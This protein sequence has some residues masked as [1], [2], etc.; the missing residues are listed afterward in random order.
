MS[1]RFDF[2]VAAK[3]ADEQSAELEQAL[4]TV[5][6]DLKYQAEIEDYLARGW[7][8]FPLHNISAGKCSCGTD[9]A[10]PGKHPRTPNGVKDASSDPMEVAAWWTQWPEANIGLATGNGLVVLDVDPDHGGDDSIKE[11]LGDNPAW[12][13]PTVR[14]GSGGY[15][16]YFKTTQSV[17]NTTTFRSLKGIDVRGDGGYVVAPPSNHLK[18]SYVWLDTRG[19]D[20]EMLAWPF[21]EEEKP[22]APPVDDAIPNGERNSTLA[23]LAGS[24]RRRGM[25][26]E[27]ILAALLVVNERRCN[28]P[29]SDNEVNAIAKSVSRYNP[30]FLTGDFNNNSPGNSKSWAEFEQ[31]SH[32]A[33]DF[34]TLEIPAPTWLVSEVWPDESIGFISGPAKSFKSFFALEMAFAVATGRA[35]LDRFRIPEPKRVL[36]IQRESGRVAFRDRIR[37]GQDRYGQASELFVLSNRAIYLEDEADLDKL[38]HEVAVVKPSLIVFDPMADFTK[39]NENTTQE[40]S[41]LVRTL[42][43]LRDEFHTSICIV[44][45]WNKART[46]WGGTE[47][48]Q[49]DRLRG[50]SALYAASEVSIWMRRVSDDINRS[51][52]KFELKDAESPTRMDIEFHPE[53][54]LIRIFDPTRI[55]AQ[56]LAR[57]PRFVAPD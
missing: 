28:P 11:L 38:R 6:I 57:E 50:N 20:V 51:H 13:T 2:D 10:S 40:M 21:P 4:E 47:V 34:L 12:M 48:R 45:H 27:E 8:V 14:T 56:G 1:L 31:L 32:S 30:A 3:N 54:G 42:R 46:G 16:F 52:A 22:P 5:I 43:A 7:S 15:H 39:A 25:S 33:V 41:A 18:G 19:L 24:M 23:S 37:R 36:Y 9:C 35:F 17:R 49:G 53:T 26:E 44:H 55:L 29:L